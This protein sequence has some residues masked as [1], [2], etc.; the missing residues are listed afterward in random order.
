MRTAVLFDIHGNA[1]ALE[2]VLDAAERQGAEAYAIGGDLA[3][4]G[5]E[6]AAAVDRLRALAPAVFVQGN[7]DRYLAERRADAAVEWTLER[8][9]D[10]R[11]AWLGALPTCQHLGDHDAVVVHATPR[12]DEE[13]LNDETPDEDATAMLAGVGAGTLLVGHVHLQYRRPLGRRRIVNPGSVGLPF[14]GD[15]DAAWAML[16]GDAVTLHRT[17]YD[18]DAVVVAVEASDNPARAVVAGRLRDARP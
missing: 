15:R 9:G 14:D 18:V 11:V 4:F 6:P 2:A 12:G 8:L 10:E 17:P 13:I 3:L 16:D 7:T 5:P 1:A